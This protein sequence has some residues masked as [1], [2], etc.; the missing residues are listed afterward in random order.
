MIIGSIICF[1]TIFLMLSIIT[2]ISNI[3]DK[4][5]MR[6]R[7]E[8]FLPL[9]KRSKYDEYMFGATPLQEIDNSGSSGFSGGSI[10]QGSSGYRGI[11]G[12][13]GFSG[14]SGLSGVSGFSGLCYRGES[15]FSGYRVAG[16]SGFSGNPDRPKRP[17]PRPY[18]GIGY[19]D[20]YTTIYE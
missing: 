9:N 20:D 15:G 6:Y 3:V 4:I 8:T 18:I 14:T 17:K 12:A 13:S 5:E 19:G 16:S 1:I 7:R 2:A 10:Y 11:S